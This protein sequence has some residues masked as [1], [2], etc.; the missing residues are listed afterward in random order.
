MQHSDGFVVVTSSGLQLM[1][2]QLRPASAAAECGTCSSLLQPPLLVT[3]II[4]IMT[5]AMLGWVSSLI[6]YSTSFIMF[7]INS[8]LM[9][10]SSPSGPPMVRPFLPCKIMV[11]TRQF[12]C[13]CIYQA[14]RP[15]Y[16]TITPNLDT[17]S[18]GAA[19]RVCAWL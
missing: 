11:T 15:L 10:T 5:R 9:I 19:V 6:L 14:G 7:Y 13:Q 8:N 3:R 1:A 16:I 17:T 4:I 18:K 12:L 2:D